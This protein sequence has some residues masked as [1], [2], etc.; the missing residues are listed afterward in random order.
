MVWKEVISQIKDKKY[1]LKFQGKLEEQ[2]KYTGRILAVGI[3]YDKQTKEHSCK[4]EV[5]E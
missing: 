3:G 1:A 2:P 4:V 5:L